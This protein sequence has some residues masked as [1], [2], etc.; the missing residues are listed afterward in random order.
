M[1]KLQEQSLWGSFRSLL[2]KAYG[3]ASRTKLVG[4]ASGTF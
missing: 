1:G 2:E 4:E 3:E